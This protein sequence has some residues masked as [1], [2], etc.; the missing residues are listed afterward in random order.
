MGKKIVGIKIFAYLA[1]AV[2]VIL[3]IPFW[4]PLLIVNFV[5]SPKR[6]VNM[7]LDRNS[8]KPFGKRSLEVRG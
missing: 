2:I 7:L 4:V 6:T 8:W 3:L 1:T 5:E